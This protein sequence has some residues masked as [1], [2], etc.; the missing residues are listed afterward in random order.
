MSKHL[1]KN[2]RGVMLILV[3]VFTGIFLLILTAMIGLVLTQRK[4]SNV[5]VA[6]VK[7]LHI[8]EAGID[9]YRWHLAHDPDDYQDGTNG[10]GPYE[11]A[12]S[13]PETGTIGTF[14]LEIT[15]PATG[16]TIVTIK[17]TG[18]VNEYPNVKKTIEARYG[19]PSLT[20]FSFLTNSDVWF[21]SGENVSGQMHSNGG[22][23][24]D[25]T[26]DSL[27]TS[28]KET[29][30]CTSTFGCSSSGETKPGV[31]GSG[32]NSDLWKYP[33]PEIDFNAFTLDLSNLKQL[34]QSAGHYYATQGYGYHIVFKN[35]GT[36]DIYSISS[37]NPSIRQSNSDDLQCNYYKQEQINS[38]SLIGNYSIPNNGVIFVE[39]NLWIEGTVKGNVTVAA[40]RFP[41]NPSTNANIHINNNLVYASR[42]GSNSL[43]LIAQKNIIIPRHAPST[44]TI[45]AAMLAQKGRVFRPNYCNSPLI[46]NSIEIYGGIISNK[47]WTWSWVDNNG[48]VI[49]GY[50]TT[51]T[52]YDN[53]IKFSPPPYFPTEKEYQLISWEEL[54]DSTN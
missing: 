8:A 42:D 50:Q 19:K 4:L 26:N 33:V 48:N 41:D 22:I 45:D 28:A 25:G 20:R 52:I 15:P 7:A 24:M 39:D 12:Y 23:R 35:D 11:H 9:Y 17:S 18:W 21:G 27:V 43:G 36:Y 30:T 31:W 29:Y 16:T 5:E 10:P 51:K 1:L 44:M 47:T 6:K 2:N 49:D 3:I 34:A 40:A 32:P 54:P 53:D 46:Q 38:E 13:D 14:S 37:L